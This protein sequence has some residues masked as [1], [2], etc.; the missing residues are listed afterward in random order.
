[1]LHIIVVW[2]IRLIGRSTWKQNDSLKARR[3]NYVV[4]ISVWCQMSCHQTYILDS[5]HTSLKNTSVATLYYLSLNIK[6]SCQ[7]PEFETGNETMLHQSCTELEEY[8]HFKE[9]AL[10]MMVLPQTQ[11]LFVQMTLVN[12]SSFFFWNNT[13]SEEFAVHQWT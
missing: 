13:A 1:M 10:F 3:K 8:L 7:C 5:C 4:S 2:S 9:F 12:W 11:N 6:Q